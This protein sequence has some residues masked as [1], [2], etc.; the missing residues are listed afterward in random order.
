MI[1]VTVGTHEQQ[2]NRLIKE[3]DGLIRDEKITDTVFMQIGYSTYKPE[4]VQWANVISYEEMRKYEEVSDVIITHGGPATFMSVLSKGKTPIVVPRLKKFGEH[5]NDHQLDF[6]QKV[7]ARGYDI[8]I[9]ENVN[10]LLEAIDLAKYSVKTMI[11][12]TNHFNRDFKEVIND[13]AKEYKNE[14]GRNYV[15]AKDL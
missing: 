14:K 9:V 8:L 10:T 11:S 5:I 4:Y 13:L 3:I 15:D 2:F 7:K 6:A 1:F 12:N